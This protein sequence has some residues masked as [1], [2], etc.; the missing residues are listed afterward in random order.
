M[1]APVPPPRKPPRKPRLKVEVTTPGIPRAA[2]VRAYVEGAVVT[3][4]IA[5]VA[6]RAW[7]IQIDEGARYRAMAARQHAASMSI[8]AP[9]DEILDAQGRPLAI[10]AN[11][12]SVWA[13][14]R[15]IRDVTQTAARLDR[16]I[17]GDPATF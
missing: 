4:G 15:E 7:G 10:S 8:P 14:P 12:D 1:T 6:C 5:G 11:A 2:R 17:G 9:R 13:N 3:A 16:L